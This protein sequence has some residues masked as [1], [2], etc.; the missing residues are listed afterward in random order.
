MD[1]TEENKIHDRSIGVLIK[2][3][4]Q[5]ADRIAELEGAY[6]LLIDVCATCGV[7]DMTNHHKLLNKPKEGGS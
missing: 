3:N 2:E 4:K 1:I 5:Q 6:E 7:G